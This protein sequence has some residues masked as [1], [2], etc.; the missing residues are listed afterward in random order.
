MLKKLVKAASTASKSGEK[1]VNSEAF[2][3]LKTVVHAIPPRPSALAFDPLQSLLAIGTDDG[4]IKIVGMPGVERT[5]KHDEGRSIMQLLFAEGE[6]ILISVTID[7]VN[8]WDLKKF[9]IELKHRLQFSENICIC[10]IPTQS[11]WMYVGTT[12][13]NL[14]VVDV[15]TFTLS[16][17]MIYWNHLVELSD[18]NH[19]GAVISVE[20]CP[21]NDQML[22][23]GFEKGVLV[24][25]DVK[26]RKVTKR[27]GTG[28]KVTLPLTSVCWFSDGKQFITSHTSGPM[29]IWNLKTPDVPEYLMHPMPDLDDNT[30]ILSPVAKVLWMSDKDD[31][32]FIH[33]GGTFKDSDMDN[34]SIKH[35]KV[36]KELFFESEVVDFLC[37]NASPWCND[38]RSPLALV[39][40]LANE[41]VVVDVRQAGFPNFRSPFGLY[42]QDSP[43][44][45][46]RYYVDCKGSVLTGLR[47]FGHSHNASTFSSSVWPIQGGVPGDEGEL[48]TNDILITGHEDGRL[49]FWDCSTVD[50]LLLCT[51]NCKT[52]LLK[53]EVPLPD[54]VSILDFS[55]CPTSRYLTVGL[56]SGETLSFVFCAQEREALV[57]VRL[58]LSNL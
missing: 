39:I 40:L 47:R 36:S 32:F 42:A 31:A 19:P 58:K 10:H 57:R 14:Y 27:F 34:I 9:D 48:T 15:S 17:Y 13:G 12:R 8:Y 53:A 23:I 49:M 25:W 11:Y 33:S 2:D 41:L 6:G 29:R 3:V 28:L 52:M 50:L 43:V 35:N 30:S 7:S 18:K 5:I 45:C 44:T 46:V 21:M 55:F 26:E 22:L 24:L 54:D 56:R 16:E 51:L 1:Q 4:V 37:I 38:T 20:E